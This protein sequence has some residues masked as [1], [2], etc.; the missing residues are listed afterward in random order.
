MD[1]IQV[2]ILADGVVSIKTDG[3]SKKNHLSADELLEMVEDFVGEVTSKEKRK[4]AH[5]HHHADQ[6]LHHKH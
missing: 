6:H 3:I 1:R 4:I 5:H 2:E